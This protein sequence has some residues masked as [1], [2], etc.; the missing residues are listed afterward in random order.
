MSLLGKSCNV[1][2]LYSVTAEK[3]LSAG[4]LCGRVT[5]KQTNG[6]VMTATSTSYAQTT[7]AATVSAVLIICLFVSF[8]HVKTFCSVVWL[9]SRGYYLHM[10]CFFEAGSNMVYFNIGDRRAIKGLYMGEDKK[11]PLLQV[12]ADFSQVTHNGIQLPLQRIEVIA[13]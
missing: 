1:T 6:G 8:W 9:D 5:G 11:T 12:D 4:V 3:L 2:A 7:D 13:C 10:L